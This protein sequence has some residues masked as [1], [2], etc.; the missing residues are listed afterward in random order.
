[1]VARQFEPEL[2]VLYRIPLLGKRVK[3]RSG[4]AY[5]GFNCVLVEGLFYSIFLA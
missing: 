1:M 2:L 3:A 5:Y 4:F